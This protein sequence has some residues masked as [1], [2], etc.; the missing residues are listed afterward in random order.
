MITLSEQIQTLGVKDSPLAVARNIRVLQVITG[1]ATGGATNVVLDLAHH[2]HNR[3]GFELQLITG[4]IPPGRTDVTYLAYE[5]GIPTEVVPSLVNHI[6]P[7]ENLKAVMDLRRLM[8]EGQYDIVH[9]HSSVAG[10]VGRIAALTAGVPIII[11][12]VHGWGLHDGMP[13]WTQILY[14]T[15]E[16]FCARFTDRIITVSEPDIQKGETQIIGREDKF[17]LIYNGIDLKKFRQAVD[18]RR[19]RSELGLDPASKLVGMVGRLDEQKNPVDFIKAAALV[20]ERYEQV[21]FLLIGDGSL[22][23]E[24]ERLIGELGLQDKFFLLGFRGD[25]PRILPVLTLTAMSSLWEGLPLAFLEAMS[26]GKPVVA[27]NIDGAKDV[28][29]NG[30]TGFL[31]TP[32]QPEEMGERIL[33]CLTDEALCERMGRIAQQRSENYSLERMFGKVEAVYNELY[34]GPSFS[35]SSWRRLL[36][37]VAGR[38]TAQ[39]PAAVGVPR[40]GL[41]ERIGERYSHFQAP[42]SERRVLL[43][44]GDTLSIFMAQILTILLLNKSWFLAF[45]P[46]LH[47]HV[48]SWAVF[49]FELPVWFSLAWLND[50]YYIPSSYNK[51]LALRR[52]VQTSLMA[53]LLYAGVT[54]VFPAAQQPGA[55]LFLAALAIPLITGWRWFYAFAFKKNM[56]KQRLL[57]IGKAAQVLETVQD[58]QKCDWVN[59]E[60]AGYLCENEPKAKPKEVAYLGQPRQLLSVIA[61]KKVRGVVVATDG[62]IKDKLLDQLVECQAL[63]VRVDWLPEFYQ[64]LYQRVPM[65]QINASWAFYMLQNRPAFNWIELGV[66]RLLD[67]ALCLLLLPVLL[68]ILPAIALAIKLDSPGPVFYRQ[69]R[70]GR[71]GSLYKIFKFRTM[72]QDAEIDGKARW[73]TADDL[74]ITRVGR[75][76]RKCRLDELPQLFNVLL[77][78]MSFVGPRPE[79]PEFVEQLETEIRYYRMRFL[80]KPGITG[81]AQI[82][83]DYGN[84]VDHARVKLQ[85]DLYYV[86]FWS[87]LQDLYILF[88]TLGVMLQL[89]GT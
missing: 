33:T 51:G 72:V 39:A 16:R 64:R 71:A 34:T 85:Y 70:C 2:F 67:L 14:L 9:T 45:E 22:R 76:L 54:L 5:R 43:G 48:P 46:G 55:Y 8:I 81:W 17:S 44:I 29:V 38:R 53:M 42:I 52:V 69:V 10:I 79:R 88:K 37:W 61:E 15:L 75:F 87:I 63:G 31:V 83:Q 60:V 66:K 36:A 58:I 30:E 40:V 41:F 25:V 65:E 50:L 32:H 57:V 74:R 27:N 86:R 11:H 84:T 1:L 18:E 49:P 23:P 7:V 24:C 20:A 68:V 35:A 12:H 56:F 13:R 19:I 4:P 80:V 73:A 21:Q 3:P 6:N 89:K 28:I 26:A 77:G 78:E 62:P 82:N 47:L 59:Y